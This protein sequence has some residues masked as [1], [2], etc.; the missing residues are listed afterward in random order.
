MPSPLNRLGGA[1]SSPWRLPLL[2]SG[3]AVVVLA[4]AASAGT[5]EGAIQS[6]AASGPASALPWYVWTLILF[7]TSLLIGLVGVM[8]GSGGGV[9]FVPILMGFFPF[10]ADFVRGAG[11]LVALC[12]GLSAGPRFLR[13]GL[14]SLRLALPA[15]LVASAFS[16]GGVALGFALP[17]SVVQ[18]ALGVVILGV[19]GVMILTRGGD[20]PNTE[21][22]DAVA[23][24]LNI[25]RSYIEPSTGETVTWRI[26]HAAWGLISFGFVGL[27]AG[28]FGMG[29]GWANVP[30]LNLVMGVPLKVAVAV[31]V[32]TLS[33]TA[34]TAAWSYL[35]HGA[36]LP[37]I[38][39][40]S[41]VG[42]MLGSR[43]GAKV[44]TRMEPGLLRYVVIGVLL[45]AGLR[46][47]GK[48]LG[49]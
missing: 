43:L 44:L 33:T 28:M 7:G 5:P 6:A 42:V 19:V 34:M 20:Y 15:A 39:V 40:P 21:A 29:A 22:P 32:F 10:H 1:L 11:I 30:V 13:S 27:V 16:L 25:E 45:L 24:L 48:G 12:S 3:L 36:V 35:H 49:V 37:I 46:A 4:V 14:V 2:V 9:L 41:L 18:V 23:E 47:M 31:S 8:A 26:R 38:V 17:V